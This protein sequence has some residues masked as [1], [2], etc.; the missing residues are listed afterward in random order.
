MKMRIDAANVLLQES[1]PRHVGEAL[2]IKKVIRHWPTC[3]RY[4]LPRQQGVHF[5]LENCMSA[6]AK[7]VAKDNRRILASLDSAA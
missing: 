3:P 6:A 5:V 1:G 7:G 2:R 4:L